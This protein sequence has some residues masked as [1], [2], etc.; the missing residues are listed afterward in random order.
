MSRPIAATGNKLRA[1]EI[2][3]RY[4]EGE[5]DQPGESASIVAG[6]SPVNP[7]P[8]IEEPQ[9]SLFPRRPRLAVGSYIDAARVK[10]RLQGGVGRA[11][12]DA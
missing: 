3:W 9:R 6:R 11:C 10:E 4:A 5:W 8:R 2:A 7:I 12:R 1:Y